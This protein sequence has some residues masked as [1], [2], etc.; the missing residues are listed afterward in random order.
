MTHKMGRSKSKVWAP[1]GE[2]RFYAVRTCKQCGGEVGRHPA[3]QFADESLNKVC[4][5]D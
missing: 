2:P 4:R 1:A 5:V 3:G